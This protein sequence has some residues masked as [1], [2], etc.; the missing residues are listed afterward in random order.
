MY[1]RRKVFSIIT[2]E[3]GEEKLFSVNETVLVNKA[4]EKLFSKKE[5]EV[6]SSHKKVNLEDVES[7]KGLKRAIITAV[8]TGGGALVG[9]YLSK[10]AADK[11]D[12]EG[13]SDEKILKGARKRGLEAGALS[14]AVVGGL[15]SIH[16]KSTLPL[17]VLPALGALGGRNAAG[18]NVKD[19]LAKRALKEREK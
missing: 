19:R 1:V 16:S 15:A 13:A 8:P 14:G 18:V 7:N 11:L 10:R 4:D 5:D 6:K 3:M 12:K 17:V 9:G 2:D